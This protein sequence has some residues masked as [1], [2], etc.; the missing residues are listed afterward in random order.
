M[1][2]AFRF[3]LATAFGIVIC[4]CSAEATLAKS[5]ESCWVNVVVNSEYEHQPDGKPPFMLAIDSDPFNPRTILLAARPGS[6]WRS[7]NSGYSW[8]RLA[9]GD[10]QDRI[11]I[12][13][14]PTS[15]RFDPRRR[16]RVYLGVEKE[17]VY[18]SDDSGLNWHRTSEGLVRYH[19]NVVGFAFPSGRHSVLIGSDGGLDIRPRDSSR[20]LPLETGLPSCGT[21]SAIATD[22]RRNG[23]AYAV[24]YAEPDCVRSGAVFRSRDNGKTWARADRGLPQGRWSQNP[25]LYAGSGHAAA[26]DPFDPNVL[27]VGLFGGLYRSTDQGV[28]WARTGDFGQQAYSIAFDPR[29]RG[30]VYAGGRHFMV[31]SLDAGRTWSRMERGL[32]GIIGR[33][34]LKTPVGGALSD[35]LTIFDIDVSGARIMLAT[36]GGVFALKT[37]A[38]H[39]GTSARA[40]VSAS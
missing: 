37:P 20:W 26:L 28:N 29:H 30:V 11:D 3:A 39:C 22:P 10:F 19:R 25:I 1:S 21:V 17:G 31:R 12:G 18:F 33:E 14:N 6:V 24:Y 34:T 32:V 5:P 7:T 36:D 15:L 38:A 16:G 2:F 4:A 9:I 35:L 40:N 8:K 23:L 27:V 13:P